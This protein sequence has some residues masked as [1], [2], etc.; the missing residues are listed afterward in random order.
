M[1]GCFEGQYTLSSTDNLSIPKYSSEKQKLFRN[2]VK[3]VD[4]TCQNSTNPLIENI[5]FGGRG[6]GSKS[7][8]C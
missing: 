5:K 7:N 1:E 2:Q 4:L 8:L 3:Y 6:E